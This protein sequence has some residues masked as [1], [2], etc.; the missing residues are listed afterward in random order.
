M[1]YLLNGVNEQTFY[2]G[3]CNEMFI[4]LETVKKEEKEFFI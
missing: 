1:G 4:I 3:I 2:F